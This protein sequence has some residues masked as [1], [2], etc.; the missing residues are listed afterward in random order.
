MCCAVLCT[1]RE[2]AAIALRV[3]CCCRSGH[4]L[5][6]HR[7]RAARIAKCNAALHE[8]AA[9][10][11]EPDPKVCGRCCDGCGEL[12]RSNECCVSLFL[13]AWPSDSNLQSVGRTGVESDI[14]TALDTSDHVPRPQQRRNKKKC[15]RAGTK[16][17]FTPSPPPNPPP[18]AEEAAAA[19][20]E[21][22][23]AAAAEGADAW[24]AVAAA[25]AS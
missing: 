1:T 17:T 15:S 10:H 24:Q 14:R 13:P 5:V 16:M 18:R 4:G 7:M 6:S 11:F 22:P 12:C 20:R 9:Q 8:C 23:T 19:A 25:A 3:L 21:H 2:R